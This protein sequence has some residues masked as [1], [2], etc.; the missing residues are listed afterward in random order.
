[1]SSTLARAKNADT[2]DDGQINK[3]FNCES[4]ELC[5]M[6]VRYVSVC[7]VYESVPSGAQKQNKVTSQ[8]K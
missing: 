4:C 7:A 8:T 1:M 2:V 5:V 6:G 3:K